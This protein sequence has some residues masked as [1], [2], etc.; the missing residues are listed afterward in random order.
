VF[1]CTFPA[2]LKGHLALFSLQLLALYFNISLS[3]A[4]FALSLKKL[5]GF[6]QK[7]TPFFS[8]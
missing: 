4:A 6:F 2:A 1:L 3:D 5:M 7:G 8:F